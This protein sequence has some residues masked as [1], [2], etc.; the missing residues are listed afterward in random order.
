MES[1]YIFL[2]TFLNTASRYHIQVQWFPL[3]V[4]DAGV[5]EKKKKRRK[6]QQNKEVGMG[7]RFIEIKPD[8]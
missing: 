6:R 3:D 1:I 4:R 7:V 5:E 8:N 2:R